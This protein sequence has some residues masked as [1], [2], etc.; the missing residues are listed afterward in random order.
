MIKKHY[1]L[2]SPKRDQYLLLVS[3]P[4]TYLTIHPTK[5][6]P[7]TLTQTQYNKDKPITL[8]EKIKHNKLTPNKIKTIKQNTLAITYPTYAIIILK[9]NKRNKLKTKTT[10]PPPNQTYAQHLYRL[11]HHII[12]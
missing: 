9:N 5:A 4:A 11:D 1:I 6:S 10:L 12:K 2:N 3:H 8:K 7:I